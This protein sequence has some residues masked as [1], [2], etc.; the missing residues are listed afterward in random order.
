[1]KK[2]LYIL[3]LLFLSVTGFSQP[4]APRSSASITAADARLKAIYN[5]YLPWATDTTLNGGQDSLG[6]LLLVIKTGDT[7]LY[8]RTPR[9]GGNKWTKM[10]KSGD[11]AGGV[12]TFNARTGNVM[13][14]ISDVTTAL[15]YTPPNPNG[16]NLQYIAGDG[17]KVTFPT[18]PA[19]FNP[20]QGYGIT[21]TGSYPNKTF[22]ADTATLFPA[23]RAT[24]SSGGGGISSLNGLTGSTQSFATGTSGSDLGIS[25]SGSTH[26]FNL[27]IVSSVNT[28]KVTPTLF[29]LWNSKISNITGLISAGTN[30]TITGS[31]TSGSPYVINSTGGGGGGGITSL[32]GLTGA[33]QTFTAN[34]AGTD[35]GISS[36]GSTHTFSLPIASGTNTGKLSNTDWTTFNNKQPAGNYITAL[37][38]DVGATGPGSVAATIQPL[39]VTTGKINNNAVTY[40]KIQPAS[41]QAL[42]G[43]TGAGN[44]Q[45]ITLGTNLSMAGTVLNASGG[46]GNTNSNV[47]SGYRWAIPDTNNIKTFFAGYGGLLDST[48]NTNG[49]TFNVDTTHPN[50]LSTIA[51]RQKGID[52]LNNL[53]ALA[54]TSTD[55]SL[56]Y[57]NNWTDNNDFTAIGTASVAVNSG[58]LDFSTSTTGVFTN[59]VNLSSY[60][61]TGLPKWK[62]KIRVKVGT[63]TSTSFGIGIGLHTA[64]SS[65]LGDVLGRINLSTAGTTGDLFLDQSNGTQLSTHSG[66]SV[67]ANDIVELIL[68]FSDSSAVFT[69]QNITTSS[70]VSTTSYSFST[71]TSPFAPNTCTFSIYTPGGT[72]QVQ[73]IDISTS[74]P[75]NPNLAYILD[76]RGQVYKG[77]SWA[78]RTVEQLNSTYPSTVNLGFGGDATIQVLQRMKE[79]LRVNPA[80]VLLGTGPNDIGLFGSTVG[81]WAARFDSIYNY[82]VAANVKVYVFAMPEDSTSGG[83]SGLTALNNYLLARYPSVY[84]SVWDTMSTGNKLKSAYNSGDGV[85]PNQSGMDAAY[86]AFVSS[87]KIVNTNARR[88]QI[89][90]SDGVVNL[91]GDSLWIDQTKITGGGGSS[92]ISGLS[93]NTLPIATSC[94]TLG[95]SPISYNG[96]SLLSTNKDLFINS[97]VMVGAAL[98]A[99]SA[100]ISLSLIGGFRQ[101]SMYNSTNPTNEQLINSYQ[102]FTGGFHVRT[103][104][105]PPVTVGTDWFYLDRN[106]ATP[107][108]FVIPTAKLV[109]G[110]NPSGR[111]EELQIT[112]SSFFSD[113]I[114]YPNAILKMDTN[115]LKPVVIDASGNFYK[116]G[117]W[118]IGGGGSDTAKVINIGTGLRQ[119]YSGHDT[120]FSK[121]ILADNGLT[122]STD[123]DSTNHIVLGGMLT[124]NTTL[125]LG[126]NNLIFTGTSTGLFKLNGIKPGIST[127]TLLVHNSDSSIAQIPITTLFTNANVTSGTYTPTLSNASGW[128]V[129]PSAGLTHWSRNGS[130]VT[131]YGYISGTPPGFGTSCTVDI[132]LPTGI[133]SFSNANNCA[134]LIN[135]EGNTAIV[136]SA[137]AGKLTANTGNG[138][139]T[140]TLDA[141][142]AGGYYFT[143]TYTYVAP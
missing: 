107:T 1:M 59:Y 6:A 74:I 88:W 27:P 81:Q 36:A 97:S 4:W 33:T 86:R 115:T 79:I 15:G 77:A 127:Y 2:L 29:N 24:I 51:Y 18:I 16:T 142:A 3:P 106:G 83:T 68:T 20:L 37:T 46:G 50:G 134:G 117:Y 116:F 9:S 22:T 87:G 109:L 41:G 113:T 91:T 104:D 11:A 58:F 103:L 42:L 130:E 35:F 67:S 32:N 124:Q 138:L 65:V 38:G 90:T 82:L 84:I 108:N 5:F 60:G 136:S 10:L 40:G 131:L 48:T 93:N 66:P 72:Q 112:G 47:G 19:Q 8:I 122:G 62:F 39:A 17:S 56:Y 80:Q 89:T 143:C 73:L 100:P 98:S 95:N 55:W 114:K 99:N 96:S 70:I 101:W 53:Y 123:S 49:L 140:I 141:N 121:S 92:G 85:H 110:T 61:Y 13:L 14:N 105:G 63:I 30:V 119:L 75:R 135:Y 12:L 54:P 118:P 45:E 31:G 25:S 23:L 111:S 76:S 128:V 21:I 43:A 137:A 94:C 125:T 26:T 57:K 126:S 133:S 44:Y 7:S 129:N 102:D 52:S 78:Q 34:A 71:T 120:L 69:A 64:N 132:S 139:V 28:G